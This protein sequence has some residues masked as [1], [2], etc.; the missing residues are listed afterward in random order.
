MKLNF[1]LIFTAFLF[2]IIAAVPI[3]TAPTNTTISNNGMGGTTATAGIT[4]HNPNSNTSTNAAV[5][6]II[7]AKIISLAFTASAL[8]LIML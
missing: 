8:Y 5:G 6:S 3:L 7:Y 2:L 1:G 4:I